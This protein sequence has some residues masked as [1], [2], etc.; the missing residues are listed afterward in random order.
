MIIV[1]L[2]LQLGETIIKTGDLLL[3]DDLLYDVSVSVL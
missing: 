1:L 2:H 3:K